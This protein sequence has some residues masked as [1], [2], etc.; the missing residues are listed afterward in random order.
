VRIGRGGRIGAAACAVA[1]ATVLTLSIAPAGDGAGAR[2]T[3]GKVLNLW[4]GGI[5]TTATPGT[6]YRKWVDMQIARLKQKVPG[7][8]VKMTLLPANNDQLAARVESAFAAHKVPDLMMLYSGAYTTTYA[9]GL[10][11]LN[12]YINKTP[13][14]YKSLSEWNWSCLDF[15]CKGGKGVIVAVPQ[16]QYGFFLFYNNALFKQAGIARPPR[17]YTELYRDCKRLKAKGITPFIYGDRDGYTTSNL[18]TSNLISTFGPGDLQRLLSGQMKWTDPK[19]VQPLTA[20][21]KLHQLGCVNVDAST[22]EQLDDGNVFAAGKGAMFE[23]QPQFLP[24]FESAL[25]GNLGIALL[26][27]SGRGPWRNLESG[28]SGDDWVIPKGAKNPQLA[29]EMIKL[30]SDPIAGKALVPDLGSPPANR[31]AAAHI[32]DPKVRFVSKW[33]AD[34][35][36][37]YLDGVM[38]NKLALFWY[39]AL[40]QAFALKISPQQ[41]LDQVQQQSKLSHP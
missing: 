1:L 15:D 33:A 30:M 21:V 40:Q 14:F 18:L 4:L 24:Q 36:L 32:A 11:P 12:S 13:G 9:A 35:P 20:I 39:K 6:P 29:W 17:T 27:V 25:H 38:P 26:P 19:L 8:K 37:P 2:A 16:D 7:A 31:A 5:L 3:Q 10:Q 34:S 22:H 23:G 28:A 41:A